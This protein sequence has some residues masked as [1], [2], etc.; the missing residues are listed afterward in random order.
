MV[1]LPNVSSAVLGDMGGGRWT[2]DVPSTWSM[3]MSVS[4][5]IIGKGGLDGGVCGQKI[6]LFSSKKSS[7]TLVLYVEGGY[8]V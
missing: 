8:T 4:D 3:D 1:S 2:D 5:S 6:S 7:V